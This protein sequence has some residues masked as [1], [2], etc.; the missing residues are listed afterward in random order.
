M[1]GWGDE[2]HR[3]RLMDFQPGYRQPAGVAQRHIDRHPITQKGMG[4]I[5]PFDVH[6]LHYAPR[7]QPRQ[8]IDAKEEVDDGEKEIDAQEGSDREQ[9]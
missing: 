2:L 7:P 8:Q 4:C 1:K 9:D 6:P 3:Q 5:A